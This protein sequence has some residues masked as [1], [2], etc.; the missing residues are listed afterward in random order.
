MAMK[1]I[2]H[3]R[4]I[5]RQRVPLRCVVVEHRDTQ[6]YR[7]TTISTTITTI[8]SWHDSMRRNLSTFHLPIKYNTL[9][10]CLMMISLC[11]NNFFSIIVDQCCW[12]DKS[13]HNACVWKTIGSFESF[14]LFFR[15]ENAS[16]LLFTIYSGEQCMA[17]CCCIKYWFQNYLW[18]K[19]R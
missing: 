11:L 18:I 6:C 5:H 15:F 7:P 2:E 4:L 12:S 19:R 1:S 3:I 8:L 17:I 9:F 13:N 10:V 14:E 16:F